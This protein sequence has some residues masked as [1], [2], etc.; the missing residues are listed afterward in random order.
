MRSISTMLRRSARQAMFT[1]RRLAERT[2]ADP[3][4][5]VP[6]SV[7]AAPVVP[8]DG[9]PVAA[10]GA[11]EDAG[12]GV[13]SAAVVGVAHAV[14]GEEVSAFVT[15]RAGLRAEPDEL[16]A[17]CRAR[18]AGYK[19]P[20]RISIVAELPKSATGKILKARLRE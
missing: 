8:G 7:G 3:G 14:L 12:S 20:R 10:V 9:A 11:G 1:I 19:Y 4:G 5:P 13:G 15:L 17:F 2:G 16:I 18:L 6:V